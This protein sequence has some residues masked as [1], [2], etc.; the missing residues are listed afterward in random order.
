MTVKEIVFFKH[1]KW[2]FMACVCLWNVVLVKV[3]PVWFCYVLLV[4]QRPYS[5]H[6]VCATTL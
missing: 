1:C 4:V 2:F 3:S 5:M 6:Y